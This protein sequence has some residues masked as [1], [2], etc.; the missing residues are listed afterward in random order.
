MVKGHT[1][2]FDCQGCKQ[3][4][5]FSLFEVEHHPDIT[6]GHCWKKY[7]FEDEGLKRQLKQFEGLCRQIQDSEEILGMT[8]IGVDVGEHQ[9]KIPFKL[10]L[11]R[12]S[13]RLDLTIGETQET[14][15]FRF[16]PLK[17]TPYKR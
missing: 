3:P 14:L 5:K 15:V 1:L 8:S 11:T 7:A 2:E 4:V 10:L 12:L 17:D 16:E 9:V 13:S 6:C